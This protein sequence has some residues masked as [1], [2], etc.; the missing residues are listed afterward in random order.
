MKQKRFHEMFFLLCGENRRVKQVCFTLIELLVV[1]A[2]I[3]ILAAM[4]LPALSQARDRAKAIKCQNNVGYLGK[5]MLFYADDNN[6]NGF[7]PSLQGS[8]TT[9]SNWK[10]AWHQYSYP[11]NALTFR[12]YLGEGGAG[13]L[14]YKCPGPQLREPTEQHDITYGYNYYLY[15]VPGYSKFSRHMQP[16]R[17]FLFKDNGP[18]TADTGNP[19][20]AE[21]TLNTKPHYAWRYSL[22]HSKKANYVFID[23]HVDASSEDPGAKTNVWFTSIPGTN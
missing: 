13:W 5:A 3:A 4:L 1:I 22:R 20:Y 2:I 11:A 17:T 8:D 10:Y 12:Q 9:I 14:K 18:K 15:T 16:T 19:W 23:G 7:F 21:Q 6:G